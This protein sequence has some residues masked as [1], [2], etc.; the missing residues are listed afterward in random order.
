A[1]REVQLFGNLVQRATFC[2]LG[3]EKVSRKQTLLPV[4]GPIPLG[5]QKALRLA[6]VLQGGS[7]KTIGGGVVLRGQKNSLRFELLIHLVL[8]GE[9]GIGG[10]SQQSD[11][12]KRH[13]YCK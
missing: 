2:G 5:K 8:K 1:I 6:R 13:E 11:D 10:S 9:K 3:S 12:C 4:A 7:S